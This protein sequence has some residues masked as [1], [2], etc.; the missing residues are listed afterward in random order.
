VGGFNT[1]RNNLIKNSN[2]SLDVNVSSKGLIRLVRCTDTICENNSLYMGVK[3]PEDAK[4]SPYGI[5]YISM[6]NPTIRN[7]MTVNRTPANSSYIDKGGHT[8][9]IVITDNK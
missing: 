8:G 9:N 4:F 5:K 1:I 7:N 3:S 2:I 6:V